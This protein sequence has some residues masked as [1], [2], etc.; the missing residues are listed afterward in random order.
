MDI[1]IPI[2]KGATWNEELK[3]ILRAWEKNYEDLGNVFLIGDVEWIKKKYPW[4]KKAKLV[5]CDDPF[6]RNKDGN[7]IRKVIKVIDS[8][9]ISDPFIRTSDDQYLLKKTD[10]FK[11]VYSV[12]IMK[13]PREWFNK[14]SRW[15]NR[16]KRTCRILFVKKKSTFNYDVHFGME[17]HHDF[18][19]IMESY[20]Y[21]KSIGYT[22]NTLYFNNALKEHTKAED[23]RVMVEIPIRD[24]AKVKEALKG[25]TFLCYSGKGGDQ[26]LTPELKN[27]IIN[28]FKKKSKFEK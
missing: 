12:D 11:P 28:K 14:G 10:S 26:A 3:Y 19:K 23:I 21:T 25:K 5:N 9:E 4:L 1:A 13:K 8:G 22:I 24:E 20:P 6:S 15:K 17:V 16:L 18:K 7:I 2:G 27:V